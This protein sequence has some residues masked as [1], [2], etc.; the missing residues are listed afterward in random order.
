MSESELNP[1]QKAEQK[2]EEAEARVIEARN[3]L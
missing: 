2:L 3:N 1:V